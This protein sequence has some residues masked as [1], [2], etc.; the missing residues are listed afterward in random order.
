MVKWRSAFRRDPPESAAAT[1]RAGIAPPCF[2]RNG[3]IP[4]EEFLE[5]KSSIRSAFAERPPLAASHELRF[6]APALRRRF[7][8][9]TNVDNCA[10]TNPHGKTLWT[11]HVATC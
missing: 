1:N 7:V 6:H 10:T 4:K 2:T 11:F 9:I 5:A 3:E 8:T